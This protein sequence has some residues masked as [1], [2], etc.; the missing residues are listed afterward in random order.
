MFQ[1]FQWMPEI[2]YS[3][4]LYIYYVFFLYIYMHMTK[5]NLY[6]WHSKRLTTNNKIEQLYYNKSYVEVASLS[7]IAY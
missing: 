5:F 2:V 3:T 7:L 1:D 6:I 4:E